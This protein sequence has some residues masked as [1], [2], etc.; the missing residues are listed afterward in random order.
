MQILNDTRKKPEITNLISLDTDANR[1]KARAKKESTNLTGQHCVTSSETQGDQ[2]D[3]KDEPGDF[4]ETNCHWKDCATEFPTQDD[5][6]K[7]KTSKPNLLFNL[8]SSHFSISIMITFTQTRNLLFVDG[9][10]VQERKN[11][12][13]HNT[14]WLYICEDTLAK[15][16]INAL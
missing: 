15:N 16:L 12:L 10:A 11:H 4:I 6:V 3:L 8:I 13:R 7:V 9:K 5:L 1:N 2:A 14:C